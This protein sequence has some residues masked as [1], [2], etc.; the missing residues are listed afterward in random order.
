MRGSVYIIAFF[1]LIAFGCKDY[2]DQ[3][4]NLEN[5]IDNLNDEIDNLENEIDNLNN[6]IKGLNDD[7]D[8]LLN[9][10]ISKLQ[11]IISLYAAHNA[12]KKIT[13]A[14]DSTINGKNY[15]IISFE[16][17]HLVIALHKAIVTSLTK[18]NNVYSIKLSDGNELVFNQLKKNLIP[19]NG[20]TLLTPKL[21][22]LKNTE[23][24]LEFRV[25][26][27]NAVFNYDVSSDSC[28]IAL[29]QSGALTTYSYITAP[30]RFRLDRIEPVAGK[31]GQYRAFIRDKGKREAY[32][33]TI[34][35]VINDI[36]ENGDSVQISS[37]AIPFERKKDTGLPVVVIH[38]ADAAQISDKVNWIPA[39]MTIDGISKFD[40]YKGTISI[41]GRGNSTW[42]LPKKP[43]A[44]KLDSKSEILG[45]PAHKR[46]VL[47]ANYVDRT[48]IRNHLAF[49]VARRTDLEWTPR[50]KFVEVMLND[51]TIGNYYLCEQVRIDEN[52]VNITEMKATDTGKDAITGGYLLE[53]D[54]HFDEVNKFR[55]ATFDLPVMIKEP[56]EE[57]L[58][59][60][61][62]DYIRNY[63]DSLE[64]LI[65]SPQSRKYAEMLDDTTF[66][67]WWIVMELAT[68]HESY[69]PASF[70]VYKDRLGLLK[71]GPV[72][73]F[74][75]RTFG[76]DEGFVAK[77]ADWIY[78]LL[79]DPV[80][81][82]KAR[83]RWTHLAPSFIELGNQIDSIASSL[84]ISSEVDTEIWPVSKRLNI[85]SFSPLNGDEFLPYDEAVKRLKTNYLNRVEKLTALMKTI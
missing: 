36:D 30:D 80:F 65:S 50:G 49:E 14:R 8:N 60:A 23:V 9:G 40:D 20:L 21:Q 24:A 83:S 64:I 78:N 13:S 10:D 63:I 51:E 34:A 47:L 27:S 42:P 31:S 18:E 3:I 85:P 81:C 54:S 52:R 39:E 15:W 4:D 74:D 12:D 68:S 82:S 17:T 7:I 6:N 44:I 5:E 46:W 48:M 66:I 43:Y 76:D 61:Q 38:T 19:I 56:D 59:P 71:A 75:L 55:S 53:L 45:M 67:D 37:V 73:D 25:N 32:N 72:W 29:D 33:T 79:R 62:F 41:R 77:Y 69:V 22:L 84:K 16:D 57:T 26:P 11:S 1:L 2:K 58:Q 28:R 70:Y 35:L